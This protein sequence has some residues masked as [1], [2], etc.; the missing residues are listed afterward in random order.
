VLGLT[1]LAAVAVGT[2]RATPEDLPYQRAT[3]APDADGKRVLVDWSSSD[4]LVAGMTERYLPDNP[5]FE[6]AEVWH[7]GVRA[8]GIDAIARA[9]FMAAGMTDVRV[10]AKR[11]G[12]PLAVSLAATDP[13]IR[14]TAVMVSGKLSGEA[15][16]GIGYVFD[17]VPDDEPGVSAFMAPDNVFVALG[18]HIIPEVHWYLGTTEAGHDLIAEGRLP[19]QEAVDE[20]S[21]FFSKWVAAYVVPLKGIQRQSLQMMQTW[22]NAMNTCSGDPNCAIVPMSDGSGGWEARI[23]D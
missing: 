11:A 9:A 1:A 23:G 4:D 17:G 2:E 13:R 3:G 5:A 18:G 15:A 22:N 6:S 19:P 16:S 8:Q 21:L 12:N 10:L 20:A 7:V 14:M